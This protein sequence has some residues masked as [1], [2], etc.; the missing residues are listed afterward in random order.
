[1]LLWLMLLGGGGLVAWRTGVTLKAIE[2]SRV[3]EVARLQAQTAS[4]R[5]DVEAARVYANWLGDMAAGKG[6]TAAAPPAAAATTAASPTATSATA[7]SASRAK[8]TKPPAK[9]TVPPSSASGSPV[10][11]K[12]KADM[13]QAVLRDMEA[14]LAALE[15]EAR[16][17]QGKTFDKLKEKA[18]QPSASV[19]EAYT[20]SP[21]IDGRNWKDIVAGLQAP[22]RAAV[23]P[24]GTTA[25][26]P[27]KGGPPVE[28]NPAPPT[29]PASASATVAAENPLWDPNMGLFLAGMLTLLIRIF[30]AKESY[31][32]QPTP[33]YG[34][35]VAEWQKVLLFNP[36]TA[37]PRELKR[38]MNLSRYAV[39]RLQT[40][41]GGDAGGAA[42]GAAGDTAGT[43]LPMTETRIVE[44]TAKW[45]TLTGKLKP[46]ALRQTLEQ[47]GATP[48]EV[49]LFLEIVGDL[50]DGS[51]G[52]AGQNKPAGTGA[53]TDSNKGADDEA[54]RDDRQ[55]DV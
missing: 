36:D 51:S 44:L 40:A 30:R 21:Q 41:M 4:L 29:A 54:S 7:A 3:A 38:F 45:L 28:K 47:D 34:K 12:A 46:A 15:R 26:A 27:E 11:Y 32:V 52:T 37:S 50:S 14:G 16:E 10:L 17:G 31:Q 39:A 19:Y 9:A 22:V 43:K 1:L 53:D 55:E 23:I 8:R 6:A 42:S 20:A 2:A 13:M 25:P 18:F 49:A 5:K 35:A 48:N 24:I 33:E